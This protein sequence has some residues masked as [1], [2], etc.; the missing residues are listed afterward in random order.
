MDINRLDL[1]L[2][3]V[4]D[5]VYRHNSVSRAAEELGL[6]QPAASQAV[7][8]LRLLLGNALFE[9]VHGGVRPT[10]RAERLALV[11]RDALAALEVGLGEAQAFDPRAAQQVFRIHLSDIGEARFL[12][13]LMA[14]LRERAPGIRIETLPLPMAEIPDALDR[15]TLD[16]AIGFLPGVLST[17]RSVLLQDH[18]CVLL[19]SQHPLLQ[20]GKNARLGLRALRQLEFVAVRSHSETLRILQALELTDRIRL[21]AAH[22]LAV[23]SI[24]SQTDLA[25]IMPHEIAA[26]FVRGG[27][28]ALLDAS[29]PDHRFAV[30][31]HWSRRFAQEPAKVWLRACIEELFRQPA[32]AGA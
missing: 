4:F 23:P 15:G 25:V 32:A 7:T 27:G 5:A 21:S 2:L 17:E 11:V 20:K 13:A 8:R 30:S 6:S 16:A 28:Y 12:P 31:L 3:R 10:P 18:Y 22:F 19:R 14:A 9:R 29:L 24:V 26:G 1:N